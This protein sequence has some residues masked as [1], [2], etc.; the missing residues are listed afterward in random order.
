[1]VTETNSW[2]K[3]KIN[4]TNR[5]KEVWN[6]VQLGWYVK[7]EKRETQYILLRQKIGYFSN[8]YACIPNFFIPK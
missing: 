5:I 8:K 4:S 7:A 3:S 6:S 1:M 2:V